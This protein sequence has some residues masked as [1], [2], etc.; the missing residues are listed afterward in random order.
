MYLRFTIE[1]RKIDKKKGSLLREVEVLKVTT[2]KGE[3]KEE[4]ETTQKSIGF[5]K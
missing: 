5:S 2:R 3:D 4:S 1:R